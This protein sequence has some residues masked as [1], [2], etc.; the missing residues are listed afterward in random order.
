[1]SM[2]SRRQVLLNLVKVLGL[3]DVKKSLRYKANINKNRAPEAYRIMDRDYKWLSK[4]K[5]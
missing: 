4:R 2:K 1:M 3:A 5:S